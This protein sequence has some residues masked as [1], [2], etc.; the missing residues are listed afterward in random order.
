MTRIYF[1]V[2]RT[3][4]KANAPA[5]AIDTGAFDGPDARARCVGNALMR[6]NGGHK[7]RLTQTGAIR[8]GG[9]L[10]HVRYTVALESKFRYEFAEIEFDLPVE[11]GSTQ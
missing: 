7:F 11:D 1:D 10:T 8:N 5:Y 4:G 2:V 9:D 3:V 6:K